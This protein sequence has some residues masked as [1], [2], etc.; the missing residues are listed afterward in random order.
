MENRLRAEGGEP[1]PGRG[2][3]KREFEV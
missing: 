2:E 3:G 1:A